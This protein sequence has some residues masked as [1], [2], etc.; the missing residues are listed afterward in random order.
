MRFLLIFVF[1][2]TQAQHSQGVMIDSFRTFDSYSDIKYDESLR[3]HL[4]FSSKKTGSMTSTGWYIINGKII[5]LFSTTQNPSNVII[6]IGVM[7]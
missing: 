4:H 1:V 5:I 7:Q 6:R 2:F 3:P